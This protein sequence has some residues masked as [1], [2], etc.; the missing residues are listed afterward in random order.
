MPLITDQI[1]VSSPENHERVIHLAVY[2]CNNIGLKVVS[3][4]S[5]L[6]KLFELWWLF[7]W[8]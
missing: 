4:Y 5:M 8:A 3:D 2:M 7:M 1:L 6:F